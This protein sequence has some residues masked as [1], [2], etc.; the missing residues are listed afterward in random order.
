MNVPNQRY[1]VGFRTRCERVHLESIGVDEVRF[2]FVQG[3]PETSGIT[4][5]RDTGEGEVGQ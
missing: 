2:Q 5:G 1:A 3:V 4:G